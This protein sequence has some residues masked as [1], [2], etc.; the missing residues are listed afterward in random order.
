MASSDRDLL[1]RELDTAVRYRADLQERLDSARRHFARQ[2][3]SLERSVQRA[4]GHGGG[5]GAH[6]NSPPDVPVYP[7]RMV[8]FAAGCLA[9]GD[10]LAAATYVAHDVVPLFAAVSLQT[11][12]GGRIVYAP[13]PRPD[14]RAGGS[15]AEA[16]THVFTQ[17]ALARRDTVLV[18]EEERLAELPEPGSH[19]VILSVD[20]AARS[21]RLAEALLERGAKV[22][23][24]GSQPA[25]DAPPGVEYRVVDLT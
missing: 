15:P 19:T 13:S 20:D 1:E 25:A 3:A 5:G 16:F 10:E 4:E 6:G 11:R 23:I 24:V 22:T 7:Q 17:E 21:I 12:H 9:L 14:G 8:A 18:A 2:L